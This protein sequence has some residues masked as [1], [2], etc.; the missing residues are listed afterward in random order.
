[1]SHDHHHHAGG[2]R[3][4]LTLVLG[5]TMLY[6]VVEVVVGYLAGSLALLADAG[7]MLTDAGSLGLA[8]FAMRLAE[9][10]TS[11]RHTYGLYRAEILAA[12]VNGMVLLGIS[13]FVLYQAY[14]RLSSPPEVA[15]GAVLIVAGAGLV[16]NLAGVLVLRDRV[17]RSLNMKAA[18]FEVLSDLVTSVGVIAAAIVMMTTGWYYADPLVSA[19]IGLFIIPRT[20]KLL[21]EG[22]GVLLEATPIGIDVDEVKGAMRGVGGVREVHDLHIWSL[23]SGVNALSAHVR[24]E[25]QA[26]HDQVREAV[27]QVVAARFSIH[28]L[29]IQVESEVSARCPDSAV[30]TRPGDHRRGGRDHGARRRVI[31]CPH[32]GARCSVRA[33][34]HAGH[35]PG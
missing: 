18:Y 14:L 3:R 31:R 2:N 27:A 20:W 8:L 33:P 32:G 1:M 30:R 9:R 13:G 11:A 12:V 25:K 29:T 10:P 22:V 26:S 35:R 4:R 19:G 24:L 6:L 17:G 34:R 16:V 21:R 15:G 23:T 7:H 28:H 5:L